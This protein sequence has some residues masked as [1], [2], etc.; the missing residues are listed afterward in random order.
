MAGFPGGKLPDL[1]PFT[2][3]NDLRDL[4]DKNPRVS[5]NQGSVTA[6]R[7]HKK[8]L[9]YQLDIRANHGNSGGPL[10]NERGEV[11]GVLY[12]GIDTMQ[13]INY[14]IPAR[15]AALL[16]GKM[17]QPA[18]SGDTA[19]SGDQSYEDFKKSGEFVIKK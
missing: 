5:V 10:V 9:R 4:K 11:I 15:Y 8:V 19:A 6:I 3:K 2:D 17:S 1:A 7:E 18:S 13:S 14:A 12:A 16:A